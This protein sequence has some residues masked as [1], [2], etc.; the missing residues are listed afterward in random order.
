MSKIRKFTQDTSGAV[1]ID[2]VALAAGI[3]LLGVAV[4]YSVFNNGVEPLVDAINTVLDTLELEIN[5][6]DE[7][8]LNE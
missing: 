1:T 3:L 5:I 2:W 7:P 4:I 6:G 8:T